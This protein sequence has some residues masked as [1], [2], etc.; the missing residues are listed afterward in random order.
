MDFVSIFA[1]HYHILFLP[2]T[3]IAR[4]LIQKVIQFEF[5]LV[6]GI[7]INIDNEGTKF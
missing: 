2:I 4:Y 1:Q 6:M 5:G 7:S 3:K